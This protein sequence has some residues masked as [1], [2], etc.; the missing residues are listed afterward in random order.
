[1]IKSTRNKVL[2]TVGLGAIPIVLNCFIN[3][4]ITPKITNELG[5][6][7]YGYVT[8][9]KSFVSYA[10]IL[11]VALNSYA[12]RY[13]SVSFL[14]NEVNTFKKYFSTVVI[15][16][17]I[18]AS[19]L[20]FIGIV[21]TLFLDCI[22]NID[23]DIVADVKILFVFCFFSFFVTTV[24]T[25]YTASGH[26]K[27]RIDIINIIKAI[28]YLYEIIILIVCFWILIPKV[29]E[30]GVASL[31][32]SLI[33][34][35]GTYIFTKVSIHEARVDRKDFSIDALKTL[36]INGF[37]N[38]ANNLGNAL[39]TGLD[40]LITNLMLNSV[41][42]GQVSL[43]KTI[44]NIIFS[45]YAAISQAFQPKMLQRYSQKDYKGLVRELKNS[46]KVSGIITNCI[47]AGFCAI[48]VEFINLWVPGQETN[49]IYYLTILAMS[50]CLTEGC[51]YPLYYVY[52]L[53]VKNKIPCIITIIGGL[54]NVIG[55]YVLLKFTD[56]GVY[57]IVVT[58]SF[59]MNF[60]GLVTNPLYICKCLRV[61]KSTFYP[62][63]ILNFLLAGVT[64]IILMSFKNIIKI[65]MNSWYK[66]IILGIVLAVIAFLVQAIITLIFRMIARKTFDSGLYK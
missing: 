38:S 55:M 47:F 20:L 30:V 49:T 64:T 46:M 53:E 15:G 10:A 7:S 63:I 18:L 50:P 1:M 23:Q 39:N 25:A 57:A 9:A 26:I 4:F 8:L 61:K 40:L 24:S 17:T 19:I 52:T 65:E 29:W 34:F 59:V 31:I 6:S 3:L 56:I 22:I 62:D 45:L 5:I 13:L 66:L 27:D 14:R 21:I 2:F 42:M 44:N 41:S 11:T 12:A 48:G 37:W 35:I 33:I 28:S 32:A 16:D 51:V 36:V 60:I 43:A 58:T 54:V